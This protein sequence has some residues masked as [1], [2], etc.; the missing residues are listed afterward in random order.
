M[1]EEKSSSEFSGWIDTGSYILNAQVSGSIYGG[2]P[3]NKISAF[4]GEEAVGKTF[5]SLG[6]ARTFQ[7]KTGGGIQYY[8]TEA[9]TTNKVMSSRG[10]DTQ[11]V[12]V[13]EPEYVEQFKHRICKFLDT[14]QAMKGD[15]PRM[16]AILDSLG[17]LPSLKEVTDAGE[18]KEVR[19]MTRTQ[20]I[21][22]CFRVVTQRAARAKV[23]IIVVNHVYTGIGQH[24]TLEMSGGGGLKYAGS[25]IMFLTKLKDAY[26]ER[27]NA[28]IIRSTLYK[29]RY[30]RE[31]TRVHTRLTFD[32]GL[33]RYF[34]L[35]PFAVDAGILENDAGR[36]KFPDGSKHF[37][38]TINLDPERFWTPDL[39]ARLDV[40]AGDYFKYGSDR[41]PREEVDDEGDAPAADV[42]EGGERE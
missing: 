28:A 12:I 41:E 17:N 9:D 39:L 26:A 42:P 6:V 40:A 36:I 35:V 32:K 21:R 25:T 5:Y 18:G 3:D 22:S 24:A 15:K 33:D 10:I 13:N 4:A 8:P 29:S 2:L 16:M 37:E 34:G 31:K 38:K 23:P 7:E 27:D 30:T 1:E 19:D 20:A 14:Y 11:R